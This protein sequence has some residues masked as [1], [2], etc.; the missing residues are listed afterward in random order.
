VLCTAHKRI[1][2]NAVLFLLLLF[3]F[4]IFI[5]LFIFELKDTGNLHKWFYAPKGSA[6]LYIAPSSRSLVVP[7]VI[8]SEFSGEGSLDSKFQ[9]TGTR[10]LRCG[11]REEERG[12]ERK[13]EKERER[14]R[15]S[16]KWRKGEG[17][18]LL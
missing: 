2:F 14:E 17:G 18:D 8:S 13:R 16:E 5:Y 10:Y 6:F 3:I 4:T 1:F 11:K 7:T 12:R 9:Y 15:K